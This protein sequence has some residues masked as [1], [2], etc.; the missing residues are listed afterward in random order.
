[1]SAR[2]REKRQK[3]LRLT[4]QDYYKHNADMIDI[5]LDLHQR[6]FALEAWEYTWRCIQRPVID[7]EGRTIRQGCGNRGTSL[8]RP[9]VCPKCGSKAVTATNWTRHLG[10]RT[11]DALRKE[12]A[13]RAPHSVYHS[14]AFYKIPVARS[15]QEK[16]WQGAELVFDI[17][18]DH[19]DAQC[20]KDHDGWVCANR[21]C[22]ESGWGNPPENGCPSCGGAEF[23]R[24]KW[25]CDRCIDDAKRNTLKVYD[26]FL[27][28]DLGIDPSKIQL[29][30]SGHR[31]YHIR[32]RD[33]HVFKVRSA[34]RVEIV[35][36][37]TG[38][39]LDGTKVIST[40]VG[41]PQIPRRDV[42]GWG[43]RV[44]DALIDFL[45]HIDEYDG[46]ERWVPSLKRARDQL[47]TGL[48]K[49][50]PAL[51]KVQGLGVKSWQEIVT[52]AVMKYGGK[53]DV[54]VTH[55]I[56]RVIR[57]IGSLNGKTG[58][59]VTV[60]DRDSIDGFDPFRDALAFGDE[61]LKIKVQGGLLEVPRF[62]IG[63]EIYGPYGDEVVELPMNAAMFLLCKGVAILE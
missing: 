25:I 33:K 56:H 48:I 27:V 8:R 46:N 7:E 3:F 29:N 10:F 47:V 15:M 35:H 18:A 13:T 58:F 17:D 62:R 16:E 4:F 39:G 44:A 50:P 26:E 57:L 20:T 42:P 21:D 37:I 43:G 34:G 6:E 60:L 55:D 5:P 53:I 52:V 12:L 14:A 30:Y 61:M 28:G 36:T 41:V 24:R 54:P 31:G 1:M 40:P 51:R 32:V 59:A 49:D 45:R 23:Y 2:D 9:S 63:D 22:L 19:L 11:A 38:V